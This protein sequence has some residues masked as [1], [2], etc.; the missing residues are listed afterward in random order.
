[1][2]SVTCLISIALAASAFSADEARVTF[3][4]RDQRGV[5]LKNSSKSMIFVYNLCSLDFRVISTLNKQPH[6]QILAE[7]TDTE[8][9]AQNNFQAA[10]SVSHGF[11]V[12]AG[13]AFRIGFPP[14]YTNETF[15]DGV[16]LRLR[17]REVTDSKG[18]ELLLSKRE[19]TDIRIGTNDRIGK[20]NK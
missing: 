9:F 10:D 13:A 7:K 6:E 17:Y 19:T 14:G 15:P 3:L 16:I 4:E 11:F 8:S 18:D 5:I 2:K 1:M 20:Q 12:G